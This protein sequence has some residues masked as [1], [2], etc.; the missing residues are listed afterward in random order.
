VATKSGEEMTVQLKLR[1]MIRP[2]FVEP[3]FGRQ[4]ADL[5]SMAKKF[6]WLIRFVKHAEQRSELDQAIHDE[7]VGQ[8]F[9]LMEVIKGLSDNNLREF[10]EA[11]EFS[12]AYKSLRIKPSASSERLLGM[13]RRSS[14]TRALIGEKRM[15]ELERRFKIVVGD[16]S[17]EILAPEQLLEEMKARCN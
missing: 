9:P 5:M 8:V 4:F 3:E 10:S 13:A 1:R 16:Y 12:E 2:D 6:R 14:S 15:E 11:I 7:L 17:F